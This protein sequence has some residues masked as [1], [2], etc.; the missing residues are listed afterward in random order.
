MYINVVLFPQYVQS[1]VYNFIESGSGAL[2]GATYMAPRTIK[3]GQPCLKEFTI[4]NWKA[5][6]KEVA[7]RFYYSCIVVY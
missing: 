4:I 1:V 3:F 2:V 7:Q 6:L 5:Q